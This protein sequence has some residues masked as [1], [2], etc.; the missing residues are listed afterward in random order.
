VISQITNVDADILVKYVSD[1]SSTFINITDIYLDIDEM[2][3]SR[4]ARA[5]QSLR[6]DSIRYGTLAMILF[7]TTALVTNLILPH[8]ISH[9]TL[10]RQAS[11]SQQSVSDPLHASLLAEEE[12]VEDKETREMENFLPPPPVQVVQIKGHSATKS[13]NFRI[14]WLTL[15]RAWMASHIL[16]STTLLLTSLTSK[17][18]TTTLLVG[19]LG[20][21]WALTRKS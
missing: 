18:I 10:T 7:A 3:H 12:G 11:L 17:R 4:V 19:I 20:I 9:S 5:T 2:A 21:S 1:Y 14:S 15:P 6:S 8:F 13:D 16:M